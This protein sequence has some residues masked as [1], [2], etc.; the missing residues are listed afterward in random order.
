MSANSGFLSF[1]TFAGPPAPAIDYVMPSFVGSQHFN[2]PLVA[3]PNGWRAAMGVIDPNLAAHILTTNNER[4]RKHVFST[5]D[6]YARDMQ[7][8]EWLTTHQGI[9]FNRKGKLFDG[10]HR[11]R[12]AVKA[13][14]TL[15][16]LVFFG[17]GEDAV[18]CA[19]DT[20][21]VRNAVDG[22]AFMGIEIHKKQLATLRAMLMSASVMPSY[23]NAEIMRL[24][25]VHNEAVAYAAQVCT[26]NKASLSG[27]VA[28]AWYYCDPDH[29]KRF[30][31]IFDLDIP[32]TERGDK[33]AVTLRKAYEAHE[34][35]S[36]GARLEARNKAL[37]AIWAYMNGEDI[38]KVYDANKIIYPVP[39]SGELQR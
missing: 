14:Y 15:T 6:R 28:R 34:S 4:Q 8:G 17:V 7:F 29:L 30:V 20:G 13:N 32:A 10:Q 25:E 1:P 2:Y 27:A 5:S 16:C 11:L 31:G 33:S 38:S 18:A 36:G 37:R 19:T 12:A 21:R 9:A 39:T 24:L 3:F 26:N 22:A 23:T 35:H